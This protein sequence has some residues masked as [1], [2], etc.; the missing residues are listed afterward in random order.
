MGKQF[1]IL[2]YLRFFVP[3]LFPS[4][5]PSSECFGTS[6][7]PGV[8]DSST[9]SSSRFFLKLVLAISK[10]PVSK[11]GAGKAR[12]LIWVYV[13]RGFRNPIIYRVN[14]GTMNTPNNWDGNYGGCC[15]NVNFVNFSN[16]STKNGDSNKL[17][18]NN[19]RVNL[20]GISQLGCYLITPQ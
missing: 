11:S 6:V 18:M 4:F 20:F 16:Y 19:Q 15:V 10:W 3:P 5:A 17:F 1:K 9:T 2:G 7:V 8:T 13:G 14:G 12:P